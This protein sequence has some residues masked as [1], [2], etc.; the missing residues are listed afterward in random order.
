MVVLVVGIML[1]IQFFVCLKA[2]CHKSKGKGVIIKFIY[3]SLY[4]TNKHRGK[5][6]GE[7]IKVIAEMFELILEF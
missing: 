7:I 3:S 6:N 2:Q 4:V 5:I 1:H